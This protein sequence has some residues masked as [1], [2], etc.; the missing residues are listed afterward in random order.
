MT[1]PVP[2]DFTSDN[3]SGMAPEI[4]E[5]LAEASK[6][7]AAAYG[8]DEITARARKA[9]CDLFERECTVHFVATGTAANALSLATL[10]PPYG[11]IFAHEEAHIHVDECAAPEFYCGGAKIVPLPGEAGKIDADAFAL[12]LDKFPR[13]V[14]HRAQPGALSLTQA[15]EYGTLYSPEEL[16]TLVGLAKDKGVPVHMDGARFANAVAHQGVTPAEA[17]WKQGIDVLSFG[18]TKNGAMAA[19]AVVFFDPEMA[20]DFFFRQKRGGHVFSKG[21][22]LS[23]QFE[24]YLKDDLWLRLARHSNALARRLGDG[25]TAAGFAPALPVEANEVFVPLALD[26]VRRL[27]QAGAQFHVWPEPPQ[28]GKYLVRLVTSF[29]TQ[30]AEVSAFLDAVRAL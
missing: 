10:S 29:A 23:A 2:L 20:K 22:F 13:G 9:V 19:E 27:K 16:R 11:V 24:A 12:A 15:T 26:D 7:S 17:S 8:S 14:V 4:L 21:R 5:A 6:G 1:A 28:D 3:A 25:L 18:A 30:E